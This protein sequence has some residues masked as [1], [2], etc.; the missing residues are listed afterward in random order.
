[1]SFA[2]VTPGFCVLAQDKLYSDINLGNL[3]LGGSMDFSLTMVAGHDHHQL[4][5]DAGYVDGVNYTFGYDVSDTSFPHAG[6]S[7]LDSDFTQTAGG[8]STLSKNSTP[9]GT[10][11]GGIHETK[12]GVFVQPGSV[13]QIDYP[14]VSGLVID[15][16][17]SDRGTISSMTNTVVETP[18]PEPASLFLLGTGLG[19]IALIRRRGRRVNA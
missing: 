3:P 8:P 17:L 11:S 12:I 2:S 13:V 16:T 9:T 10:P 7:S 18:I 4:S 6:I 19:G 14:N 15:E 5:F 1:M